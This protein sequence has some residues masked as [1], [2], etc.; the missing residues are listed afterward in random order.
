V[1]AMAISEFRLSSTGVY[2]PFVRA[3]GALLQV[4]MAPMAGAQE[5]FLMAPE[6]E[7]GICGNRG[8]GKT[9]IMLV[10]ALSGIGRGFGANYKAILIRRSQREMTDIIKLSESLV[11][12]IWPKAQFNKV[13]NCWQWP[14]GET[15]EFSYFDT[16]DQFGLYQGKAFA[17]IGFEE[18]TL[19]PT[20]DCY[21]L[22]FSTLRAPIPTAIMPRKVRFT[23]NPSGPGH[24][25]VKHRFQ[26]GGVP[27]GICGPCITEVGTDGVVATRR[28]IYCSYD[29]NVLL[30]H[31]EPEY[32][33]RMETACE[34]DPAKL[35]AWKYGDWDI[36]AGGAFD[37]IFFNYSKN[38]Y[39]KPFVLPRSG[40]CFMSY[41]HGSSKPYAC[42][43]WWESDG[44]DLMFA[45]GSMRATRSGD[46]F[47]IG[48]V[49]GWNGR[50]DEGLKSSIKDITIAIQSYKINRGWRWRDPLTGKWKDLFRRGVADSSIFNEENEFSVAVEF[51]RSV[52]INGQNHPG[53]EWDRSDKGPGSRATGFA[54]MRE[55]L[56]ATAP[57]KESGFR[58]AKGLFVVK[59][60]CPQFV[61]T[62]PVLPRDEKNPDTV[63][64]NTEDHIF[65]AC[66]YALRYHTGPAVRSYRLYGG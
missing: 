54:L 38:I 36:V 31:S 6:G 39:V 56:I 62:I 1:I 3:G 24:N 64:T 49:Y 29:D 58:E 59:E 16:P 60:H 43:F 18:L 25:V 50:P 27:E 19:W 23:C 42:L 30:K 57:G 10:D 13:K 65:D 35:Q 32:M 55:R 66:A 11:R 48:E 5:A 37:S 7:V 44:C 40:R 17:W 20:L 22:M 41:D 14:T 15:L 9:Q 53:I 4:A 47:L 34:G 21:L 51:D 8:G 45:D 28:M 12:P 2:V 61:R 33:R 26:L 46:L 52:L 63:D